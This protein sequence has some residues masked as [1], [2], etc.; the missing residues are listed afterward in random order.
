MS[1]K[2]LKYARG[3]AGPGYTD[4]VKP[5][6]FKALMRIEEQLRGRGF[7]KMSDWWKRTLRRMFESG[8]RRLVVRVGRR[9]GKSSTLCRVAVAL[10][11][12]GNHVIP[13]GDVGEVVIISVKKK[14]AR[15]RLTTIKDILKAIGV[16]FRPIEDGVQLRDMPIAFRVYTASFR[17]SVG[18]T[19]I[20]LIGDEVARWMDDETGSNPAREILKSVRPSMLTMPNSLEFLSSSPFSTMDAHYDHYEQGETAEQCVAWAESWVANPSVTEEDCRKLEPD[21][22]T[23]DR[24]YRAI[25]MKSGMSTF[26]DPVAL[27]QA[28]RA[29]ALPRLPQ[30]MD[31]VVA[32][33]DFG[34]RSDYSACAVFHKV[35]DIYHPA[36]TLVVKPNP[37]KPLKVSETCERFSKA[38]KRHET[39]SM[40]ADGHYREAV[41]EYLGA[42]GIAFLDAPKDPAKV[43]VRMRTLLYQGKLLLPDD[44]ELMRDLK[45]VQSRPTR[46]GALSIILPKRVGGGHA[47][48]VSAIALAAWQKTGT[49]FVDRAKHTAHKVR[50]C[51]E[52]QAFEESLRSEDGWGDD[53]DT[54]SYMG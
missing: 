45:E 42:H 8:R 33:G 40:M 3:L 21:Q 30:D 27:E 36:E 23:F 34:F 32:G 44:K 17:T 24:E 31:E 14:D 46:N 35:G 10:A 1:E 16:R 18:M 52:A 13:T 26:F 12:Y 37:G 22:E 25:P 11:L 7:H 9:G 48:L 5:D 53:M 6:L 54:E 50:V 19:C 15:N 38:L 47:D 49:P 28:V 39:L 20:C 51:V 2:L 4:S 41:V 43:Y 29:Y